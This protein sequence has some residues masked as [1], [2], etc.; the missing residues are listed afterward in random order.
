MAVLSRLTYSV[1]LPNGAAMFVI[2]PSGVNQNVG[3]LEF[4]VLLFMPFNFLAGPFLIGN[5]PLTDGCTRNSE[6]DSDFTQCFIIAIHIDSPDHCSSWFSRL[7]AG[8]GSGL[9]DLIPTLE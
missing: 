4:H 8:M 1:S 5:D 2:L 3:H 9:V 7:L 6:S